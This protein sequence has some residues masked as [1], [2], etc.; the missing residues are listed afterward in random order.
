M[1]GEPPG[2]SEQARGG[3]STWARLAEL[4]LTVQGYELEGL[5]QEFSSEFQRKTTVIRLRGAGEEGVGEDVT[6]TP[7]DHERLQGAGPTLALAGNFTVGSFAAHVRALGTFPSPPERPEFRLYRDWAFDAAAL[8]LALR[9]AG[10]SLHEV[11]GREPRGVRFVASLRLGE[12]PTL[13][14]LRRR[15]ER[16]PNARFKLDPTPSWNDWLVE[17][18][19]ALGV[20]DSVDLKGQYEGTIVDNPGDPGLYERVIEAFPHAWIEDPKLTPDTEA[21]LRGHWERVTWDAPIHGVADIEALAVKP[22][23]IN[24]KPS[25]LGGLRS[26]LDTYDHCAAHGIGCYGGGQSELGPGRGQIQYLASLFHP[27]APN[28]VAPSDYN[29]PQPP[30][31]LPPSPLPPA[32]DG[33]GFRWPT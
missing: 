31:H 3:T 11:L 26:L 17:Q 27:D 12:P 32:P 24:I 20:V 16:A 14:P 5:E 6:Y 28:D 19:V 22:R 33:P 1:S 10:A 7:A 8:D 4:P 25:R 2:T 18:L 15:L 21:V 29:L 23:M 13:D 9:Q 30:P